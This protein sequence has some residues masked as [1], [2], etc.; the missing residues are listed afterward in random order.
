MPMLK[1]ILTKS[2]WALF[3]IILVPL[4]YINLAIVAK[5][6]KLKKIRGFNFFNLDDGNLNFTGIYDDREV[7]IKIDLFGTNLKN[8]VEAYKFLKKHELNFSIP[9][10]VFFKKNILITDFLRGSQT[11]DIFL[12]KNPH[13]YNWLVDE[14]NKILNALNRIKFNHN[15]FLLKNIIIFK[16]HIYLIDFYFSKYPG[17]YDL[18]NHDKKIAY[19]YTNFAE[20]DRKTFFEDLKNYN[21]YYNENSYNLNEIISIIVVF[22]PDLEKFKDILKLHSST[23]SKCVVVNNS[24]EINLGDL[25]ENTHLISS[26]SNI[27]LASALNHGISY[28]KKTGFKMCALFDQDTSFSS[29]FVDDMIKKINLY[30]SNLKV[31]VFSPIFY[32]N[33]TKSYGH[34]IEFKFKFLYLIR[35]KPDQKKLIINPDYVITSGSFIPLKSINDIGLMLD[36]LFIDFIDIEWCLRARRKKYSIVSFQDISLEHNMGSLSFNFLGKNYPINTPQRIYY[37]FRN[38]FYLYSKGNMPIGWKIVDFSRNLLR[39]AFYLIMVD[40]RSYFKPIF[41]GI[42]HGIFKKMGKYVL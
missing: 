26:K 27:G 13:R 3:N 6:L 9:R 28:A 20:G 10:I 17:S 24:P 2:F 23:F 14:I 36:E 16:N 34:N 30:K 4:G 42:T 15:D 35:S 39:I 25:P 31:A 29:S 11:I 41:I 18:Y 37:Y 7:F 19:D 32:N 5:N 12:K 33:V 21:L 8:E 40:F 38:S 1:K 22:K